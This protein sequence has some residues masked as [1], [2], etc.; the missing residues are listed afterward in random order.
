MLRS[1]RNLAFAMLLFESL[2][3]CKPFIWERE[4]RRLVDPGVAIGES[5]LARSAAYRDTIGARAYYEGMRPLRVRGYGLVVGLG[6]NGSR[7]CPQVVFE[8]LVQTMHKQRHTTG[9]VVGVEQLTPEQL[10]VD[11]DTA[12]VV[13]QGDIPPAALRGTTFDVTVRALPGTR[14]ESLRGGRLYT[15]EL[16]VFKPGSQGRAIAGRVLARASGP[17]FMNPFSGDRAATKS[18]PLYGT[19]VGGGA[20]T[21]SRRVR[22]VLF[23]ASHRWA[24]RIQDRINDYVPGAERVAD[25]ISPSF[26]NVRIPE[27]YRGDEGHFLALIRHLYLSQDPQLQAARARALAEEV[28]APG[29]PHARIALAFEGLGQVALPVLGKLYSH[30]RDY[31]SFHAAVAGLRL[32]DYIAGDA[33]ALCARNELSP[34][35]FPAIRALSAARDVGGTGVV[36]RDLLNDADPRVRVA[37]Y[38]ALTARRDS[39]IRSIRVGGDNF[40]LDE[41]PTSR[42][43]SIYA[44]RS[45]AR[46]LALFGGELSCTPPV[47]YRSEDGT[48]TITAGT[49]ATELTLLRVVLPSGTSSPPIPAPFNLR[50]LVIL[51]GTKA[52]VDLS[53]RVTGLGLDYGAVVAALYHLSQQGSLNA[54]FVLEQPNAA[55]LFGP[56]TPPGRPESEL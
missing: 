35:R 27:A 37:A 7:D 36:L 24:R 28:V 10:I 17:V 41:V 9:R 23:E 46:R 11:E 55:E 51:L 1:G 15:S 48:L 13:V 40:I 56:P 14:T 53:G 52:G 42:P 4:D 31:V 18:S 33:I 20:V 21:E 5:A 50:D 38:E 54:E 43:P 8:G 34:F 22:L 49:N 16:R 39:T 19:V 44:K 29:A 6:K 32:G 25:A 2:A 12:V 26:V 30:P 47:L 3:G 45:G